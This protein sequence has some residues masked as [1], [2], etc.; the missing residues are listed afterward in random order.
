M[1]EIERRLLDI[2]GFNSVTMMYADPSR[3]ILLIDTYSYSVDTTALVPLTPA[4]PISVPI[5]MDS[6]S[7]FVLYYLSGGAIIP[8]VGDAPTLMNPMPAIKVQITDLASGRTYFNIPTPMPLVA[9][10]NGFPFILSSP[11]IVKPRTTLQI[12]L[13]SIVQ[14]AGPSFSAVFLTLHGARIYYA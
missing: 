4:N 7:E 5:V 8:G 3:E 2:A 10:L 6:D 14:S 9:G 11:R 12:D 1:N 13:S